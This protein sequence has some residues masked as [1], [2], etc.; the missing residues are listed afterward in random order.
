MSAGNH[1]MGGHPPENDDPFGYLYRP[2]GQQAGGAP[3]APPQPTYNQVR[4]V[5]ERTYGGQQGHGTNGYGYPGPQGSPH[6]AAPET[7]PGGA[8]Y[9]GRSGRGAHGDDPGPRRNGL[10][11]GAIAVVAA[12]VIGVGAA[13]LFSGDDEDGDRA[14]GDATPTAG[15]DAKGGDE[16][17]DDTDESDEEEPEEEP[18]EL[19]SVEVTALEL[20]N[21]ARLDSSIDGARSA[22]GSYVTDMNLPGAT[23]SWTFDFQGEPGDYR[24]YVGYSL[25]KGNQAL[26]FAVNT[27]I[28]D[29]KLT[30]DDYAEADD[31]A[32]N[33]VRTYRI[34]NLDQGQNTIHIGCDQGDKCDVIIDQIWIAENAD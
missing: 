30:M 14:G 28:R 6:Y 32:K 5:G 8:G 24:L 7:Q 34:I 11:I 20:S 15:S 33:W 17:E 3:Q 29:D 19:P 10:L 4:P 26:S 23:L 1:G 22:D 27:Q 18:E 31:W 2:D 16:G 12:V 9:G 21:G 13:I 25:P